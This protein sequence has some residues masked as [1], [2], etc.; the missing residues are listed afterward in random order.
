MLVRL[1]TTQHF[2]SLPL[3]IPSTPINTAQTWPEE[4]NQAALCTPAIP[5]KSCELHLPA[6]A[7]TP[8][9][10]GMTPP[11]RITSLAKD[12]TLFQAVTSR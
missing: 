2:C 7:S 12:L 1:G 6:S 11:G 10:I 4:A 5:G 3:S 8:Q 9:G